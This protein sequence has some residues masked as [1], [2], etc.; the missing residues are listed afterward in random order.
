MVTLPDTSLWVDFT[1]AKSPRRLKQF[2]APYLLHPTAHLAEPIVFEILRHA[3][4]QEVGPLT[5]QFET[6]PV[7][8]T[9]VDLWARATTLG[10]T[11]RRQG[12][13]AGAM[14]LLIAVVALAHEATIVTLDADLD[15][16]GV[17]AGLQVELL[18]RPTAWA[19]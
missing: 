12:H 18:T 7:L 1:R 17:L 9:P 8:S 11:C 16:I 19:S 14:D 10:Q 6:L 5:R 4:P 3:T 13:T 2:I 15:R